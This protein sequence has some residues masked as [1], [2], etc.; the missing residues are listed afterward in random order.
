MAFS[1]AE[2]FFHLAPKLA[3]FAMQILMIEIES[4]KN[5]FKS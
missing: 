3:P 1:G 5:G 2:N 4:R